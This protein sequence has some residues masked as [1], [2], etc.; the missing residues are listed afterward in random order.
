MR[1]SRDC[2]RKNIKTPTG[3][4]RLLRYQL[5]WIRKTGMYAENP[6]G[7]GIAKTPPYNDRRMC[8]ILEAAIAV[9]KKQ[10]GPE[11]EVSEMPQILP[12][13]ATKLLRIRHYRLSLLGITTDVDLKGWT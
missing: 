13:R 6:N 9:L 11:R 10:R 1:I 7:T 3:I 12:R 5:D 8:R 2:I 4:A